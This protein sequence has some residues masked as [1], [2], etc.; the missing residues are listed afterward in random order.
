MNFLFWLTLISTYGRRMPNRPGGI[1]GAEG[2]ATGGG[3]TV[4]SP[5]FANFAQGFGAEVFEAD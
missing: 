5:S 2:L 3:E 4:A 1:H